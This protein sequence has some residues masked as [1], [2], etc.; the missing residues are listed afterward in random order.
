MIYFAYISKSL[1][2]FAQMYFLPL[3]TYHSKLIMNI[4]IIIIPIII[5]KE[6]YHFIMYLLTCSLKNTCS[7]FKT[8]AKPE[9]NTKN[10]YNQ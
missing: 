7:Y 4:I 9:H 5:I 8:S 2:N 3:H 6:E 10:T 1:K